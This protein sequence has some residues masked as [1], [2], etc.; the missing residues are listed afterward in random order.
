MRNK[1]DHSANRKSDPPNFNSD[2]SRNANRFVRNQI[3]QALGIWLAGLEFYSATIHQ[4]VDSRKKALEDAMLRLAQA[5]EEPD[6]ARRSQIVA[7]V[8][9]EQANTALKDFLAAGYHASQ[10]GL[11]QSQRFMKEFSQGMEEFSQ[12]P[13]PPGRENV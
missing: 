9:S 4:W 2:V 6:I 3:S 7:G 5:E 1:A 10:F 8:L 12:A 13:P 11:A